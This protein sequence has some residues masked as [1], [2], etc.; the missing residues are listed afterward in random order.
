MIDLRYNGGGL[1]RYAN[2]LATQTAG[3]QVQGKTFIQYRFNDNN[4][5]QNET[6]P[7]SLVDGIR[8]LDLD[9][10]IVLTTG[11]VARPLSW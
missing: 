1:I 8:Q 9:Q 10:V 7:F 6:V 5:A 4:A 2:Q 3:T 11:A